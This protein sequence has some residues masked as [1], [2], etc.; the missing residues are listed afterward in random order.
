LVPP[1][2]RILRSD[3]TDCNQQA[4]CRIDERPDAVWVQRVEIPDVLTGG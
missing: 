4:S 3:K 1:G 2:A